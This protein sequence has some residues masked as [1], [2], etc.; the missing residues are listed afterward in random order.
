VYVKLEFKLRKMIHEKT[1]ECPEFATD[2]KR[3]RKRRL[4][5]VDA[6]KALLRETGERS[7]RSRAAAAEI[8]SRSGGADVTRLL[9]QQL[10]LATTRADAFAIASLLARI[11]ERHAFAS[12]LKILASS[13]P[14]RSQAAAYHLSGNTQAIPAL[15]S[16]VG[17]PDR[18]AQVRAEAAESLGCLGDPRAIAVLLFALE[19]ESPKLRFWAVFALGRFSKTDDRVQ[20][21]LRAVL[22]DRGVAPGWWSVGQEAKAMLTECTLLQTEIQEILSNPN[23]SDEDR[24]WAECY[25]IF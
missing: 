11:P 8:L 18:P 10:R 9:L 13:D 17:D 12:L 7:G 22:T 1:L 14:D 15:I 4:S 25:Q 19:E 5:V 24:R 2:L 23:A 6:L 16:V 3:F 20:P 21:G